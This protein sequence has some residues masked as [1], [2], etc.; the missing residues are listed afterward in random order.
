MHTRLRLAVTTF[1]LALLLGPAA[2]AQHP[3]MPAGLTHEEHLKQLEKDAD[4]EKRGTAA[5]GFDQ[6]A[7]THHFI[8]TTE[9]GRIAVTANNPSDATSVAHIRAH[10][11]DIATAFANGDFSA[12]LATHG[13]TPAGVA[14]LRE[15]KGLVRYEYASAPNGGRVVMTTANAN[16]LT[17]IHDFLR[18]QI[19]E[20]GTGDAFTVGK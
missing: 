19:R 8:L 11:A 10:L 1:V 4:L 15:L 5:M 2:R 6:D 13:A 18:Y 7:T 12:P 17:A 20:H 14:T 16:A 3:A 9:G